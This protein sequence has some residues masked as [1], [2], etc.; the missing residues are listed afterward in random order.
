MCYW[1]SLVASDWASGLICIIRFSQLWNGFDLPPSLV[2]EWERVSSPHLVLFHPHFLS[3]PQCPSSLPLVPIHRSHCGH[4]MQLCTYLFQSSPFQF[5]FIVLL[6]ERVLFAAV[7]RGGAGCLGFKFPVWL[8]F[9]LSNK[10]EN[11]IIFSS[12]W[13]QRNIKTHSHSP[14]TLTN[15]HTHR[16]THTNTQPP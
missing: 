5:L 16:D 10:L 6:P 1:A 15:T 3:C 13:Y 2:T 9:H 11:W 7:C 14:Y 12:S 8:G 4:I